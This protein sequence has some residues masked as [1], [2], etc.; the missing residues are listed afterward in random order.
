MR[1]AIIAAAIGG[2]LAVDSR[3]SLRFMISQP[4]VGGLLTGLALGAPGEGFL[5]GSLMQMM[6]LGYVTVRGH[7][8]P[9]LPMAG[10]AAAAVFVLSPRG[11]DPAAQGAVLF[12]AL[13]VGLGA[14]WLGHVVYRG[15]GHLTAEIAPV[16]LRLYLQGRRSTA[17][18]LHLSLLPLHFLY[19]FTIVLL[20]VPLGRALVSLAGGQIDSWAQL[21]L[22]LPAIGVGALMRL[23]LV[24]T[25]VFW[26]GAGFLFS[27]LLLTMGG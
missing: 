19:G 5:A 6:F 1:E 22:L 13:A 12:V 20:A 3:S 24:R 7:H 16:A 14:A 18:A 23:H 21:G 25:R 8:V 10:A 15:V 17:M 27:F 26:L 2:L 11:L 4:I 9:D